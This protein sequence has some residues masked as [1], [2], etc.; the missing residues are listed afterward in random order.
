MSNRLFSCVS[1][2]L[3]CAGVTGC[4]L[5]EERRLQQETP[6]EV[7]QALA[8]KPLEQLPSELS[9]PHFSSMRL[10]GTDFAL[11]KVLARNEAYTRYAI[12][13]RSNGLLITGVMNIPSGAGPRKLL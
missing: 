11:G 8:E 13:Y 9:I 7:T 3:L 6:V 5:A 2:I 12:T 1:A 10:E 4:G